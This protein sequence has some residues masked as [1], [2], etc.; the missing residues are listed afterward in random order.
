MDGCLQTGVQ[1]GTASPSMELREYQQRLVEKTLQMFA[2]TFRDRQ[3]R[4]PP[5][6]ASVIMESPTGSGK[7]VMG[8]QI[9]RYLQQTHGCRVGWVAMRRNLLAQAARENTARGFGV[10]LQLISMFDKSP[11]KVDFLVL[12]EAQHDGAMSMATLHGMIRPQKVLGLTAT[13]YRTDRIKL[14]FERVLRDVGI[15]ELIRAGYLSR[16]HHYT[17]PD[18]TPESVA[19]VYAAEP[20][21]WGQSLLFFH[22]LQHCRQCQEALARRGIRA[23]VVTAETDRER[24]IQDFAEGRIQVLLSMVILAEGFDCPSLRT[25]FCRPSGKGCTVQMCGRVFRRYP[26]LAYKQIVQCRNTRYPFPKTATPDEQYVWMD[27][28]WKSLKL[29]ERIASLSVTTLQLIADCHPRLPDLVAKH[30][31][32]REL[33]WFAARRDPTDSASADF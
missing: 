22:R 17:I 12:D 3:G 15:Q 4:C 33:P 7:T 24:Q 29:N 31:G 2:G 19:E 16:Y 21:R 1:T 30:R 5:P 20:Q 10:D 23:A 28:G 14:C 9:A 13:P 27:K 8:L 26:G 25:V 11:P 6:A 32:R 18:Y